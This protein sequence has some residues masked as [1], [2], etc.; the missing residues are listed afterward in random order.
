[1][2]TKI[3][4]H[5]IHSLGE[6]TLSQTATVKSFTVRMAPEIYEAFTELASKRCMSLNALIQD[7][8]ASAIKVEEDRE[9]YNAAEILSL[10]IE[11]CS[12]EYAF[13]AQSEVALRAKA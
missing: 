13:A 7:C 8:L 4:Y 9:M 10:D 3:W 1:L 6:G 2:I 11:E 5:S 12:V